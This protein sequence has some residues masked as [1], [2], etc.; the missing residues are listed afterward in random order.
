MGQGC[1]PEVSGVNE[2]K[3][4]GRGCVA[5]VCG[6]HPGHGWAN[7]RPNPKL[8]NMMNVTFTCFH[9]RR[10]LGLENCTTQLQPQYRCERS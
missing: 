3:S 7:V 8:Q 5:K 6:E 1:A 10:V 4:F 2:V 9:E